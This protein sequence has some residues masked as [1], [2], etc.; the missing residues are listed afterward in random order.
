LLPTIRS[1]CQQVAIG[2]PGVAGLAAWL[3][4]APEVV[5]SA[6]GAVGAAPLAVADVIKA[7]TYSVFNGLQNDL[8]KLCEERVDVQTVA[9][10]WVKDRPDVALGWLV[11]RL[12]DELRRRAGGST[13]VTDPDATTLHNALRDLPTRTLFDAFEKADQLLSLLGSGI[14]VELALQALLSAFVRN[15]GRS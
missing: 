15:R 9:Q 3:G 4:V 14:N 7:G 2:A 11:R 5:A 1:R 8:I 13:E 12:H 6:G 10:A